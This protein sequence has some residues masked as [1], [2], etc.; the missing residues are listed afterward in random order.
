MQTR[1][2]RSKFTTIIM[3]CI[4]GFKTKINNLGGLQINRANMVLGDRVK[5]RK[6]GSEHVKKTAGHLSCHLGIWSHV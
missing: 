5:E 6:V 4:R 2:N 3:A 1:G